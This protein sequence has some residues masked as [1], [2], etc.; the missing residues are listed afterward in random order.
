LSPFSTIDAIIQVYQDA[1]NACVD[2]N[3]EFPSLQGNNANTVPLYDDTNSLWGRQFVTNFR[4]EKT[5]S[6]N[7]VSAS[8]VGLSSIIL[9]NDGV[10]TFATLSNGQEGQLVTIHSVSANATVT[11]DGSSLV[12]PQYQCATYQYSTYYAAWRLVAKSF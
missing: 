2:N 11:I 9:Q 5:L 3:I 10:T 4:K 6:V 12:I 1:L 7:S 8:A